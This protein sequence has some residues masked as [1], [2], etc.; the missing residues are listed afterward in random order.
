VEGPGHQVRP[1]RPVARRGWQSIGGARKRSGRR[2]REPKSYPRRQA[3]ETTLR[4]ALAAFVL[5]PF[6]DDK[7]QAAPPGSDEHG[8]AGSG[9]D[10]KGRT[11]PT[12]A[13]RKSALVPAR[14]DRQHERGAVKVTAAS[15]HQLVNRAAPARCL[16]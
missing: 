4:R 10:A 5:S 6:G 1:A 12:G 11:A 8:T 14:V 9:R 13:P 3:G 15:V 7:N 16:I 2:I